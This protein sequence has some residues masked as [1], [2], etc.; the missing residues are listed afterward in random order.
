MMGGSPVAEG[1]MQA[2]VEA[3]Q[4]SQQLLLFQGVLA[5]EVGAAFL[6]LLNSFDAD[7]SGP[8][9]A[10]ERAYGRLFSLLA[11]AAEL[12][13][14]PLVGDAW[15]NHLLD[16]ILG[17]EN[18]FSRKAQR[19]VISE[20]GPALLEAVC[21]DLRHL[22][23][24]FRLN[25]SLLSGCAAQCGGST[26]G[27]FVPWDDLHPFTRTANGE[28]PAQLRLKQAMAA[29]SDWGL[30]VE[31]LAKYY[32][33]AGTGLFGRFRAFRWTYRDGKG[34]LEGVASLDPVSLKDLVGYE[35]ERRT[36]IRNTEHFLAGF[37]ANNVL[38]YGDRGTGKSSTVKALLN[39]YADK[40]LRL[41]EV[42]KQH[43]TDFPEILALIRDRRERF[44]LFVDDLSFDEHETS[45]KDLKAIL[46]GSLEVRP[47]NVLVYATSNRRHLVQE[48]L[49]DRP[50]YIADEEPHARDTVEEKLSFSDR[51]GITAI[52]STPDQQR[53]LTI[54]GALAQQRS[55]PISD[56]ELRQRA[57]R[58][59]AWQN[60][61]SC[62]S[63][64]QFIDYL[65]GELGIQYKPT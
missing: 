45:Y 30:L 42:P 28:E 16:R 64:R 22:Q 38:L 47:A 56:E 3:K 54:V 18:P 32:L 13:P 7:S 39:D 57:I 58:W 1:A 65:T 51:F 63:A 4:R 53:F 8:A 33:A 20:M 25:A 17:D 2:I 55:L 49:T 6:E 19:A 23:V 50:A 35:S 14:E 62:R 46:E 11:D 9:G 15:Q 34:Q 24:L 60:G 48:R 36:I 21:R 27:Q 52:F 41:I 43:L 61:R 26:A 5:D 29:S 40:G 44:I 59:A 37:P 12:N 10:V 31:D